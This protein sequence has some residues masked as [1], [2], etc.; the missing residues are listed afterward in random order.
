[1]M[2]SLGA[3]Q[4]PSLL[5]AVGVVLQGKGMLVFIAIIV[6][7]IG[8][9]AM[10]RLFK[11]VLSLFVGYFVYCLYLHGGRADLEQASIFLTL[12][13]GG[14]D[15]LILGGVRAVDRSVLWREKRYRKPILGQGMSDLVY[16]GGR[17]RSRSLGR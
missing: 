10:S 15:L 13:A 9:A 11:T 1:M 7:L 5:A 16:P 12:M 3:L 4:W 14:I 6:A 2:I 8:F 17:S